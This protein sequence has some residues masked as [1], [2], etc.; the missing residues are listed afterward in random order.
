MLMTFQRIV[1][2]QQTTLNRHEVAVLDYINQLG[3]SATYRQLSNGLKRSVSATQYMV[4][5]LVTRGALEVI[6]Y[7]A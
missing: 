3:G 2:A 4:K 6:T 1:P 7:K 5:R